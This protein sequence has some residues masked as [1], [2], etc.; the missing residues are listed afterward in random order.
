MQAPFSKKSEI[1]GFGAMGLLSGG[2]RFRGR[3]LPN[4]NADTRPAFLSTVGA[5][6]AQLVQRLLVLVV[7]VIEE[8]E[9]VIIVFDL[10]AIF[11]RLAGAPLH[12]HAH[13]N[14]NHEARKHQNAHAS[15]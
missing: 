5:W 15:E 7:I 10:A 13:Q 4:K 9:I 3:Y 14:R 2:A 12:N 8:G 11:E 1:F 6:G